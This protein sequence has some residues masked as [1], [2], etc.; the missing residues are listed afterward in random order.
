M[1]STPFDTRVLDATCCSLTH[2][3]SGLIKLTRSLGSTSL[4]V[5]RAPRQLNT[6][7]L[8]FP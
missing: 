5:H 7:D 1:A 2:T 3:P 6:P 8:V 4:Y